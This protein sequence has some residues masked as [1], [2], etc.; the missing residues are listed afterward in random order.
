MS[1]GKSI[2][3][4]VRTASFKEQLVALPNRIQRLAEQA[5]ALFLEDPSHPSLALHDLSDTKKGR[6]RNGSK[7]VSITKRYRAIFV[8]DGSTNVWYWIGSH[9]DYDT[10][11]GGK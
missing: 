7:A 10:F 6:H 5:Y 8:V 2:A 11:T 4:N 3:P 9:Q 1:P